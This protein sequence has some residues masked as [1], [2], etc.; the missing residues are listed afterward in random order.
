MVLSQ[1]FPAELSLFS[2]CKPVIWLQL[3]YSLAVYTILGD[4][5]IIVLIPFTFINSVIE[6]LYL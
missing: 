2:S 5:R 4:L 3:K 6:Y 1:W